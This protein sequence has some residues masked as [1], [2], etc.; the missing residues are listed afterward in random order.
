MN[1]ERESNLFQFGY[2]EARRNIHMNDAPS[3]STAMQL[4]QQALGN[5]TSNTTVVCF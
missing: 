4:Q 5:G 1:G 3:T 2:C